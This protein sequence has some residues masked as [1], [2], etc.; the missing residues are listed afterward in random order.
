M[1]LST[2]ERT[3][4]TYAPITIS[5]SLNE[6]WESCVKNW[7][8]SVIE[9]CS[10]CVLPSKTPSTYSEITEPS[11]NAMIW[12]H[13]SS[14]SVIPVIV[15]Q[16][17]PSKT[18]NPAVWVGSKI[19]DTNKL[20]EFS[21]DTT[22]YCGLPTSKSG[23]IQAE[24]ARESVSAGITSDTVT[25]SSPSNGIISSSVGSSPSKSIS[26]KVII[27]RIFSKMSLS[28]EKD[29]FS[30]RYIEPAPVSL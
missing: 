11:T 25:N 17:I 12:C 5:E 1:L 8:L 3:V 21:L 14:N 16:V 20:K 30:W 6:I 10:R 13:L 27:G 23:L 22:V 7:P 2:S 4:L 19:F 18:E 9:N 24:I 15:F 26:S 29:T 28:S